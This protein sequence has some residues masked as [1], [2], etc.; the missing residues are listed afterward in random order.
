MNFCIPEKVSLHTCHVHTI[1]SYHP[2][3]F[4]KTAADKATDFTR[5]IDDKKSMARCRRTPTAGLE[6]VV[7]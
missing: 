7:D 3:E 6:A 2:T 5:L 1:E 4:I